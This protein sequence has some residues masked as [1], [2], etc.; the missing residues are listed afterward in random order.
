M[1]QPSAIITG[2]GSG[3]GRTIAVELSHSGYRCLLVGR[4]RPTLD[5]TAARCRGSHVYVADVTEPEAAERIV[6]AALERF[7]RIDALVNNAGYAPVVQIETI[8]PQQ[9]RQII[10]T[11]LSAAVYLA[12]AAW[13]TIAAQK[14][15]AIVNLSSESSRDPFLGLGAYGAAKAGLNLLTKALAQEGRPIN[16]RAYAIAPAAVETG[17][18]RQIATVDQLPTE[19]TLAPEEIAQVVMQC[20]HG[21]LRHS[22][23]EVIYV[24]KG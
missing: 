15:G 1:D 20:I 7:G 3:I 22:N 17:M 6:A 19:K 12:H 16:L 2:A 8:T 23:G 21:D 24:H 11:N 13:K 18:L 4:N 14:S 10:D 5:E 9:W